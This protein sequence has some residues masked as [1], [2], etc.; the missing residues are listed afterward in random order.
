MIKFI[1]GLMIGGLIG[2]VFMGMFI[3]AKDRNED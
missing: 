2:V 3:V 1:A